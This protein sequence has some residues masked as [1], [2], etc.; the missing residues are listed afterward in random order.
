MSLRLWLALLV[1]QVSAAAP[2]ELHA[3]QV[4][5]PS[6]EQLLRALAVVDVQVVPER[7]VA[8]VKVTVVATPNAGFELQ[9]VNGDD[10]IARPINAQG[11]CGAQAAALAVVIGH[12]ARAAFAD[13][14]AA[15]EPPTPANSGAT[16]PP[17]TP[18]AAPARTRADNSVRTPRAG[19]STT[20]AVP[21]EPI[22]PVGPVTSEPP[23]V[24]VEPATQTLEPAGPA[25]R[26]FW[27][28][29]GGS[30][31][32]S[33]AWLLRPG[34]EL[35]L[36]WRVLPRVEVSVAVRWAQGWN[37]PIGTG[38]LR[39][40]ELRAHLAAALQPMGS[41]PLLVELSGGIQGVWARSEGLARTGAAFRVNPVLGLGLVVQGTV[42]DRV[43]L[44][45]G[46]RAYW[47]PK[48]ER[49][50]IDGADTVVLP[51]VELSPGFLVG[52][53]F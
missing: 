46:I 40:D 24:V 39:V 37:K 6:R 5:C 53:R 42:F 34:A 2:I 22:L 14:T 31:I 33:P 3:D 18:R 41:I 38:T 50:Q 23:T 21:E 4:R 45:G 28:G 15:P 35:E 27:V 49:F 9:L 8:R 25:P 43:L 19:G 17:A 32:G 26:Q 13:G 47:L 48:T 51:A 7:S 11:D 52:A 12:F 30:V 16:T 29:V 1:A 36:G 44:Q 20:T 10:R